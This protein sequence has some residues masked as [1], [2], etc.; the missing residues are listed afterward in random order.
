MNFIGRFESYPNI[1]HCAYAKHYKV[2]KLRFLKKWKL[3]KMKHFLRYI[4]A[5]KCFHDVFSR[6]ILGNCMFQQILPF[7]QDAEMY[8]KLK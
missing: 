5:Y 4:K 2:W 7:Y 3:T 8:C 1:P 6:L